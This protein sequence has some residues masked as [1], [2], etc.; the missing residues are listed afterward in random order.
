MY[1]PWHGTYPHNVF[2]T[3]T[4]PAAAGMLLLLPQTL[5]PAGQPLIKLIPRPLLNS[6]TTM[7]RNQLVPMVVH[8][9]LHSQVLTQLSAM[10]VP[11]ASE[12]VTPDGMFS[13]DVTVRYRG[14]TV[15][16][17][18]LGPDHYTS[19]RV[20]ISAG[21]DVVQRQ[22]QQQ[23]Q[24]LDAFLQQRQQQHVLLGPELLRFR[25]LAARNF[26]LAAISSFEAAGAVST[27]AGAQALRQL[28]KQKLEEAVLLH[29]QYKKANAE[30]F[31]DGNSSSSSSAGA[32]SQQAAA[33]GKGTVSRSGEQQRQRQQQGLEGQ[34]DPA[35]SRLM[36]QPGFTEQQQ[37]VRRS[38]TEQRQQRQQ[39]REGLAAAGNKQQ[40][41]QTLLTAAA[42]RK[43]R[44]KAEPAA[45][46][47]VVEGSGGDA[48][49]AEALSSV[50]DQFERVVFDAEFD[51]PLDL[52]DLAGPQ[53]K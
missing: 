26:A 41:M 21:T 12:G 30:L 48:D 49:A 34:L 11:F 38:R 2:T 9:Q 8:S 23:Q 7:W 17:E 24:K 16:L 15:A 22:Q 13:V 31:H 47:A 6:A 45:A 51:L 10:Q 19:N 42:V 28:L 37:R 33:G 20:A 43:G 53:A 35:L 36:H 29:Q 40:A 39:Y 5:G 25:L 3:H 14:T 27:L 4:R 18:V 52:E 32:G 50:E 44:K 46:A 1:A